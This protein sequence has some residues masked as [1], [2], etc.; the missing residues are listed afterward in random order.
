MDPYSRRFTWEVIRRRA[1]TSSIML[2]T[3]F[4]DEADLLCDRIAIMSAG[5]LACVGSPLFLKNRY[6]T[7][8]TLTLARSSSNDGGGADSILQT[9]RK[10]LPGAKVTSDVGAEL[11][12]MLPTGGS[13]KFA[14]LFKGTCWGFRSQ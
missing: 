11:H 13:S 2:T 8:Y 1:A 3:H 12:V 10:H 5:K 7:G 4:L 9:V 14:T 6:G